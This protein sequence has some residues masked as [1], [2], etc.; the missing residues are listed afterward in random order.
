MHFLHQLTFASEATV[1]ALTGAAFWVFAGWCLVMER[2]RNARR[3]VERLEQVGW[4]PWTPLF[5]ASAVI[6]GGLLAMSLP[7]VFGRI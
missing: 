4:V 2:L 7:V 3:S 1:L 5:L 6:G